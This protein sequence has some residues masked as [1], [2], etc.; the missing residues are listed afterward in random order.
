VVV[1]FTEPIFQFSEAD[2]IGEV[3]AITNST[4]VDVP[5]GPAQLEIT[6]GELQT[7]TQTRIQNR[8]TDRLTYMY[9]VQYLCL[10]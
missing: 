6:G 3:T 5:G 7:E 9:I 8:Q 2:G 10:T 1:G 4:T